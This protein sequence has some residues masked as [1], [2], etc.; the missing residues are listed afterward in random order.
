MCNVDASEF[1]GARLESIVR[2]FQ[3]AAVF[4]V[5]GDILKSL[6]GLGHD[7]VKLFAGIPVWARPDAYAELAPFAAQLKLHRWMEIGPAF[8]L[9]CGE[10]NGVHYDAREW[11]IEAEGG[12]LLVTS[13]MARA[14]TFER[15]PTGVRGLVSRVVCRCGVPDPL[16][17]ITADEG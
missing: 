11:S 4:G 3:P 7:P 9:E 6:R 12:E 14:T 16:V 17:T 15:Q 5:N 10:R 8:A 1:D 2:R 13:R